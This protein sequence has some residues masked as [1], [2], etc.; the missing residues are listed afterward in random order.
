MREEGHIL[1]YL[2]PFDIGFYR[3]YGY[4]LISNSKRTTVLATDLFYYEDVCGTVI[5][6]HGLDALEAVNQVYAAWCRKYNGM[7]ARTEKW[8]RDSVNGEDFVAVYYNEAGL[9]KGYVFYCF[10]GEVMKVGEYAY[11]D[12]ASRRGLWN[13]ISNHDSMIEK[14]EIMSVDHESMSFLFNNPAAK[15]EIIPHFMGRVVLVKDFL[16]KYIAGAVRAELN[17][18]LTVHDDRAQWNTGVYQVSDTGVKFD[19]SATPEGLEMDIN[20]FTALFLGCQRPE[21]LYESGRISGDRDQLAMLK[22]VLTTKQCAF[23]D[24]F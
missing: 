11:L 19:A 3:R 20:T 4:E 5:R 17:L 14:V 24:N 8:W 22:Q 6:K 10:K 7:L 23:I 18:V 9:P 1:S 15:I 2:G 12:E 16:D 21:F 13:F